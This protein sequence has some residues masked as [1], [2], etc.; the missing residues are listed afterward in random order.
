MVRIKIKCKNPGRILRERIVEM[1]DKL[2]L[3]QFK[4]EGWEEKQPSSDL[5]DQNEG[6]F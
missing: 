5:E 4:A 6:G 2:F 3:I 1:E